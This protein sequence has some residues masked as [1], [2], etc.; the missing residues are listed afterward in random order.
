LTNSGKVFTRCPL[1]KTAERKQRE[2]IES[3][4]RIEKVVIREL[5]VQILSTSSGFNLTFL[6][7]ARNKLFDS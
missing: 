3:L 1:A 6:I 2:N 4:T 5:L 7:I